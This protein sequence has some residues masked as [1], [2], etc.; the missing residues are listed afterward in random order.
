LVLELPDDVSCDDEDVAVA[1]VIEL[2]CDVD[3]AIEGSSL[4]TKSSWHIGHARCFSLVINLTVR[5]LSRRLYSAAFS[6]IC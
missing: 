5:D 3:V 1:D 2:D 4:I 6:T